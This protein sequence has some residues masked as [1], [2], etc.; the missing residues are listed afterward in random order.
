MRMSRFLV[1]II[2]YWF[3]KQVPQPFIMIILL[4]REICAHSLQACLE[5]WSGDVIEIKTTCMIGPQEIGN[6]WY[7]NEKSGFRTNFVFGF[8]LQYFYRMWANGLDLNRLCAP[9]GIVEMS[10]SSICWS[11]GEEQFFHPSYSFVLK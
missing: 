2:P 11:F 3:S 8:F 4:S 5:V 6:I 9:A 7:K 10:N 1:L